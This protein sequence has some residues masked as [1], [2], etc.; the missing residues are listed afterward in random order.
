MDQ[1]TLDYLISNIEDRRISILEVVVQGSI[2]DFAEYQ[3]L[4]GIIQGLDVAKLLISDLAKRLE[5]IDDE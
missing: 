4:C 3:K 5:T 2:K 1:K